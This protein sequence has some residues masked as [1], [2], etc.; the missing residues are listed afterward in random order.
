MREDL[1]SGGSRQLP[2]L[3][4]EYHQYC[5]EARLRLDQCCAMLEKGNE[6]QAIQLAETEPALPDALMALSFAERTQWNEQCRASQIAP[7]LP[8]DPAKVKAM[9]AMYRSGIS[10]AHPLY[11][12]YRG[13][14]SKRDDAAALRTIRTIARLNPSDAGARSELERLEEKRVRECTTALLHAIDSGDHAAATAL[15]DELESIAS[16]ARLE[17]MPEYARGLA[18]R[19]DMARKRARERLNNAVATLPGHQSSGDWRTAAAILGSIERDCSEHG[20]EVPAESRH[21]VAASRSWVA[22]EDARSARASEFQSRM[23]EALTTA[24]GVERALAARSLTPQ[25]ASETL[26]SLLSRW[27]AVLRC[28]LPIP[29]DNQLRMESVAASLRQEVERM[30]RHYRTMLLAA[31]TAAMAAL[32]SAAWAGLSYYNASQM[33]A[34]LATMQTERKV[35]EAVRLVAK[36]RGPEARLASWAGLAETTA[37]ADSWLAT[38]QSRLASAEAILAAMESGATTQFGDRKAPALR[39]ELAGLNESIALLAPS[40][41][42]VLETRLAAVRNAADAR[43]TALRAEQLKMADSQLQKTEQALAALTLQSPPETM[44]A[45][46]AG[47]SASLQ[48]LAASSDP[49]ADETERLNEALSL[50]LKQTTAAADNFKAQLSAFDAASASLAGSTSLDQFS[51]ALE[52]FRNVTLGAAIAARAAADAVPDA[53]TVLGHI[54]YHDEARRDSLRKRQQQA[55]HPAV[56]LKNDLATLISLQ[57]DEHLNNVY[58]V[59]IKRAGTTFTIFAKGKPRPADDADATAGAAPVYSGNFYRPAPGDTATRFIKGTIPE[60]QSRET[61]DA[62]SLSSASQFME[63]LGLATLTDPSGDT[64]TGD[65]LT[66]FTKLAVGTQFP[67][68][69]RS[70]LWSRLAPIALRDPDGWG[71]HL[72]PSL[73]ADL[74]RSQSLGTLAAGSAAWMLPDGSGVTNAHRSFFASLQ[75]RAYKGEA[76]SA[77]SIESAVFAAGLQFAGHADATGSIVLLPAHE[78]APEL[79]FLDRT[80]RTARLIRQNGTPQKQQAVPPPFSP[81]FVIP[82]DR[83]NLIRKPTTAKQR[84]VGPFFTES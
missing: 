82:I 31:A 69:L 14:V 79:W 43:F 73:A 59:S 61:V 63:S 36:V 29:P 27:D 41:L 65:L 56:V 9:D 71:L 16:P 2:S 58:T 42:P 53:T 28:Q 20:I 3:A 77:A 23:A 67:V 30:R 62:I 5:E 57:D 70:H 6:Y 66:V 24:E 76:V 34:A 4:I 51:K 48:S 46:L 49:S 25:A 84:E 54:L 64:Y 15:T 81:V 37:R 40:H 47:C 50:R 10:N 38:E 1:S 68:S 12:D 26:E 32:G 45:T 72:A 22:E 39:S 35:D 44:R 18:I 11:R 80:A 17:S 60:L 33:A 19:A 13:A 55:L 7:P 8:F 52:Q 78:K 83:L 74:N 75:N 21:A